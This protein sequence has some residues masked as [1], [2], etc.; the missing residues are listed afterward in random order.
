MNELLELIKAF[1]A[2]KNIYITIN[3]YTPC[4]A[5]EIEMREYDY[6]HYAAYHVK[7]RICVDDLLSAKLPTHEIFVKVL[8]NMYEELKNKRGTENES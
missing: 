7:K 8:N 1:N 3:Y 5:Y 2:D 6:A 4:D